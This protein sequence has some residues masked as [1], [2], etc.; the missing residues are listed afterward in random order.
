MGG[1]AGVISCDG[2]QSALAA[3]GVSTPDS[4]ALFDVL[5]SDGDGELAYSDFLAAASTSHLDLDEHTLRIVFGTFDV[6]GC[7]LLSAANLRASLGAV[8]GEW[9]TEDMI[10]EADRN[11]DG[12]LSFEE[13]RS[14]VLD[15]SFLEVLF[16]LGGS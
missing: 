2:F 10:A 12:K 3:A 9:S 4:K 5:D 16:D 14:Y 6:D 15:V 11:G 13:L 8:L 1:D 7:G